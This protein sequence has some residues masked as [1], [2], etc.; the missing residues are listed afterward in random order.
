MTKRDLLK[1]A[2]E[3]AK[4]YPPGIGM[5]EIIYL[6]NSKDGRDRLL[7]L[8]LMRK[9]IESGDDAWEYFPLAGTM[10]EDGNNQC[11]WQSL[12]VIGESIETHP[13]AVWEIVN[14][15][16]D[17]QDE[18]MRTAIANVLLEHLLQF[19]FDRYFTLVRNEV[20][21]GKLRLLRTLDM[22]SF[23][24]EDSNEKK[25]KNYVRNTTRGLP[26]KD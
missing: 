22:C 5:G 10:I 19:D 25:V 15:Y 18:D 16:G 2:F 3:K 7:S 9:Q 12:I 13:D 6:S 8:V 17:S 24:G 4:S 20:A 14:K 23:F 21:R 26:D 1:A 11:R